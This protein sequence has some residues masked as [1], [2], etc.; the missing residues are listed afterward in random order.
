MSV[1]QAKKIERNRNKP[2]GRTRAC[3]APGNHARDGEEVYCFGTGG[4][5]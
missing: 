3:T 5:T 1:I 2:D 4:G